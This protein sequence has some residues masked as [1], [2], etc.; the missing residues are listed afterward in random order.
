MLPVSTGEPDPR[1]ET[2]D[3]TH[4]VTTQQFVPVWGRV[5]RLTIDRVDDTGTFVVRMTMKQ[6]N[7]PPGKLLEFTWGCGGA[8]V[9]IVQEL[10]RSDDGGPVLAA[11]MDLRFQGRNLDELDG[12]QSQSRL[13]DKAERADG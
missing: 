10:R 8:L 1:P 12:A 9:R 13:I 2:P 3:P 6:S 11:Q 4:T 7:L 5:E